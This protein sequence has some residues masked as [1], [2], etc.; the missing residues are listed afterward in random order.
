MFRIHDRRLVLFSPRWRICGAP[1]SRCRPDGVHQASILF[2]QIQ[3]GWDEL[4]DLPEALSVAHDRVFEVLGLVR[5]A[6][7]ALVLTATSSPMAVASVL[8]LRVTSSVSSRFSSSSSSSSSSDAVASKWYRDRVSFFAR[9]CPGSGWDEYP[10]AGLAA[11]FRRR[12]VSEISSSALARV[13]PLHNVPVRDLLFL[14]RPLRVLHT[15]SAR[16]AFVK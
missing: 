4:L 15:T 13:L 8:S 3:A 9:C 2:I 5:H 11:P 12:R 14:G 10:G 7:E 6:G 16:T 1:K